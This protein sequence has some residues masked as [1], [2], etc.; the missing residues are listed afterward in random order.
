VRLAI[1][2]DESTL[3]DVVTRIDPEALA[4]A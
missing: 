1:V 2:P 4:A 3:R